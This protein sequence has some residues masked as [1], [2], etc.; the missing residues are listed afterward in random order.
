MSQI[1]T[2]WIKASNFAEIFV[3]AYLIGKPFGPREN[4]A[5]THF[6]AIKMGR[7]ISNIF[8]FSLSESI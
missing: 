8:N 6:G 4:A 2:S 1:L 7:N 5:L 3:S